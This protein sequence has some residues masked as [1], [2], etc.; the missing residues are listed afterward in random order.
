M[1]R[2]SRRG[3]TPKLRITGGT[4]RGRILHGVDD[5]R[6]R[7]TPEIV[8]GA[9]F[10][11][12]Q[13]M[14]DLDGST[15]LDLCSGSGMIGFEALSRGVSS[16]T[17]LDLSKKA[18]QAMI[19]NGESLGVLDR[20]VIRH[21][22]LVDFLQKSPETFDLIFMDPP[23]QHA[24]VEKYLQAFDHAIISKT[25]ILHDHGVFVLESAAGLVLPA[26]SA[27]KMIHQAQYGSVR[28]SYFQHI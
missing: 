7:H 26:L 11:T 18:I 8:R 19:L 23:F 3:Q 4:F 10:S 9:L 13:S 6:T 17:M 20:L 16:V 28:L 24:I 12:L 1:N 25:P 14:M 2:P 15:F 5:P 21:V 27:L 22:N